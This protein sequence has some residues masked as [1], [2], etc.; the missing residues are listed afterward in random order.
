MPPFPLPAK[1]LEDLVAYLASLTDEPP[2]SGPTRSA[3]GIR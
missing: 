3:E 1:D 2:A